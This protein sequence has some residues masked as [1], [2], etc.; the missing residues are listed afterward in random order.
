[1]SRD[2]RV[3]RRKFIQ[4]GSAGVVGTSTLLAGCLGD[5]DDDG[6]DGEVDDDDSAATPGEDDTQTPPDD[7]TEEDVRGGELVVGIDADPRGLNPHG[8]MDFASGYVA[9]HYADTIYDYTT[10]GELF[11]R[12]AAEMPEIPDETTFVVP[13]REGVTWHEPYDQEITADDIIENFERILDPEY[14]AE[15]RGFFE[16]TLVGP[17]IDPADTVQKTG[18]YEVTFDLAG[19]DAEFLR[20]LSTP[21][22]SMLPMHA[23]DDVGKDTF[24]APDVG[25]WGSGPFKFVEARSDDHY[26]FERN[27][28]YFLEG[29]YG[30][31]PYL[32]EIEFNVI[33]EGSVRHTALQTGDIDVN[34]RVS[35]TDVED[36]EDADD[37]V[38][39]SQP[40]T[41]IVT[42][43]LNIRNFEPFTK[44]ETRQALMHGINRE[45]IIQ[46]QYRDHATEAWSSMPPWHWAH[47][48]D[49]VRTYPHDPQQAQSL[50]EEAGETD[51]SFLLEPDNVPDLVDTA[52]IV[53]Q[54]LSEI[55]VDV[56]IEPTDGSALFSELLDLWDEDPVGP[57][58]DFQ[59]STFTLTFAYDPD[60]NVRVTHTTGLWGNLFYY[61]NEDVDEAAQRAREIPDTDEREQHY[62]E[63]LAQITEDVP[64]LTTVWINITVGQ[65]DHVHNYPMY[66]TGR[67]DLSQVWVED[68]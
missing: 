16:G 10:D 51:L 5:D 26:T 12:L 24:G 32:D 41:E 46:T 1:M 66:A 31:L 22:A 19:P 68:E 56:E 29:E 18:E 36:V 63:A 40:G 21:R 59:A 14:G 61:S 11:P 6:D 60:F 52:T 2:G 17:D 37:L 28:D 34:E 8:P 55:G 13:L 53:Q 67:I 7:S 15:S 4:I 30:Q 57:S 43:V 23:I 54:N 49:A 65:G 42:Q 35:G 25:T 39:R 58:E 44:K 64:H 27:P 20:H 33:P 38:L 62:S 45:A 3:D 50:L 48:E 9:R 47:D